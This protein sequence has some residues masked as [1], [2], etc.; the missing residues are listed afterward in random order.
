MTSGL[1]YFS[2]KR[3]EIC[4]SFFPQL[5]GRGGKKSL[6]A[7]AVKPE[8][9]NLGLPEARVRLTSLIRPSR[10]IVK[11]TV[12]SLDI[13]AIPSRTG[14]HL[15]VSRRESRVRYHPSEKP[16]SDSTRATPSP[17][18]AEAWPDEPCV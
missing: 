2:R 11:D 12:T 8:R 18:D 14:F 9:S 1:C 5:A 4:S 17:V 7:T 6:S 10:V 15:S 3:T 13:T 16:D